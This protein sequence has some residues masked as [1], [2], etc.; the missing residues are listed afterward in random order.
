MTYTKKE[1][2][3]LE[4][5]ATHIFTLHK[6]VPALGGGQQNQFL[7]VEK[8]KERLG[9]EYE[10]QQSGTDSTPKTGL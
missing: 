5:A 2:K 9:D 8:N 4:I 7:K 6:K 1:K 10:T 3:T